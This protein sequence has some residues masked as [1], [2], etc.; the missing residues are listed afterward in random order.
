MKT[1]KIL[2]AIAAMAFCTECNAA[3]RTTTDY[4]NGFKVFQT[5]DG[6]TRWSID[7]GNSWITISK[8]STGVYYPSHT[9]SSEYDRL[10]DN[11]FAANCIVQ[12]GLYS[13]NDTPCSNRV[14]IVKDGSAKKLDSRDNKGIHTDRTGHLVNLRPKSG[15]LSTYSSN[16]DK[17]FVKYVWIENVNK[18]KL[19]EL[20]EQYYQSKAFHDSFDTVSKGEYG[21]FEIKYPISVAKYHYM[22]KS[23]KDGIRIGGYCIADTK[24]QKLRRG[25][26]IDAG[27][28]KGMIN[29]LEDSQK[30]PK[31]ID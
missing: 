18:Q 21:V 10:W 25:L 20:V 22:P 3:F 15:T 27:T 16:R 11:E 31:L 9:S 4:G 23:E 7:G 8:P 5:S 13:F 24:T 17:D 29:W 12:Y 28:F 1:I 26:L 6:T 30:K 19:L 14:F 2:M